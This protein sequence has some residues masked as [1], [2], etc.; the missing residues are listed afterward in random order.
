MRPFTT[1]AV[2]HDDI[3]KE[4]LTMDV[5]AADL[6]Q[7]YKGTAPAEYQ[8]PGEF[9]KKTFLTKGMTYL[10]DVVRNR[11]E[12]RGGDPVIQLQTPFG[13]GKTHSLIALYHKAK[14][15]F[16]ANVVVL[17]GTAFDPRETFCGK[18]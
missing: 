4:K 6:W 14:T 16:N 18:K 2:P 9:F 15:E 13:G 17:S 12:G 8:D 11:L 10:I 3:L 5:F 1:V 7:V